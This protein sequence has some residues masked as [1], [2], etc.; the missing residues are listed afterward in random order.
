MRTITTYIN[1]ILFFIKG[2][3]LYSVVLLLLAI[4]FGILEAF[5]ISLLY[6]ML[7]VGFQISANTIPFYSLF[8]KLGTILPIGS[9]FVNFGII[10]I[11]LT[12]ASFLFQ[13][14][15]WKIA[16]KFQTT[17]II[18]TKLAIFKKL[19]YNDYKFFVDNKQGD[20]VNLFNQSPGYVNQML[21]KI[22]NILTDLISSIAILGMLY[23]ISPIGLLLVLIG[24]GT[25]Y[26]VLA[27]I[28]K[29]I[30]FRLGQLQIE[31]GE[32]ENKVVN[33]YISGIK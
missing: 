10:F 25:F 24:G 30:S 22:L 2:L 8:E 31:S 17:I 3:E 4:I 28:G 15:Y 32:S 19:R 21:E 18:K 12:A 5:N 7:S 20:L 33:E 14:I 29:S 16:Y 13:L 23:F 11:L 27:I 9:P 26:I 6:P 1:Q